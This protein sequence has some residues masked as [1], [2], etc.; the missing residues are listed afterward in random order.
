[1]AVP[2]VSWDPNMSSS[3]ADSL[4]LGFALAEQALK[5]LVLKLANHPQVGD[6]GN[7]GAPEKSKAAFT[8]RESSQ[9][10]PPCYSEALFHLSSQ[11]LR[12]LCPII[13]K[14]PLTGP[15]VRFPRAAAGRSPSSKLIQSPQNA[16]LA[17]GSN[18]ALPGSRQCHVKPLGHLSSQGG[19]R[20]FRHTWARGPPPPLTARRD[21]PH[22][23]APLPRLPRVRGRSAE[24]PPPP[25]RPRR[26][27]KSKGTKGDEIPAIPP[28]P[29]PVV[30]TTPGSR[31]HGTGLVPAP[32]GG[33]ET[34][35]SGRPG[36]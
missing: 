19:S 25:A 31:P 1:M 21:G 15:S 27:R 22:P 14:V 24:G 36:G 10:G 23:S 18:P 30:P 17:A 4:A 11:L 5:G 2:P 13:P 3:V 33:G 6:P 20:C 12:S 7:C 9:L 28:S 32:A 35:G 8:G 34:E 16:E 26:A 29:S